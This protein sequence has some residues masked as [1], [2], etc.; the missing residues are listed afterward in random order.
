MGQTKHPPRRKP[1]SLFHGNLAWAFRTAIAAALGFL[2][3]PSPQHI[4]VLPFFCAVIS[5]AC[6]QKTVGQ[7]LIQCFDTLVGA[8]TGGAI[9]S[10]GAWI[11]LQ[12]SNLTYQ[13]ALPIII[14][15]IIIILSHPLVP[16]KP[17]AFTVVFLG[18]GVP[19]SA[20]VWYF[21]FALTATTCVGLAA[22]IVAN[23]LPLLHPRAGCRQTKALLYK[24]EKLT[25]KLILEMVHVLKTNDTHETVVLVRGYRH[26]NA[27]VQ[28]LDSLREPTR[29]E[30]RLI[31]FLTCCH[32][33]RT[34][35]KSS[36]GDSCGWGYERRVRLLLCQ[37]VWLDGMRQSVEQ[38][39]GEPIFPDQRRFIERCIPSYIDLVTVI[40]DTMVENGYKKHKTKTS[41]PSTF[42][43]AA[44]TAVSNDIANK[45]HN[46]T[47]PTIKNA[48]FNKTT[49]MTPNP[50]ATTFLRPY[51]TADD[52]AKHILLL[53]EKALEAFLQAR[54]EVFYNPMFE[55][56]KP[57]LPVLIH[58]LRRSAFVFHMSRLAEEVSKP[59]IFLKVPKTKFK[60]AFDYK[61]PIKMALALLIGS[62]WF[63]VPGLQGVSLGRGI[64][65]GVT[66]CFLSSADI[67]SSVTKSLDRLQGSLLACAF[68][69]ITIRIVGRNMVAAAVMMCAW[70]FVTAF[71]RGGK[72]HGYAALVAAFSSP[73]LLFGGV[74]F[75]GSAA[76]DTF[77][78][79]RVEMTAIGVAVYLAIQAFIWPVDPVHELEAESAKWFQLAANFA[80]T[81]I[82][83]TDPSNV[84]DT[85]IRSS[86][87]NVLETQALKPKP[88]NGADA[89]KARVQ[90]AAS[91]F[92]AKSTVYAAASSPM[93]HRRPFAHV[94]YLNLLGKQERCVVH[95]A[96]I[97][98]ALKHL[99]S[100]G[101][102]EDQKVLQVLHEC[103]GLIATQLS[104]AAALV[105][106]IKHSSGWDSNMHTSGHDDVVKAAVAL[107]QFSLLQARV[108]HLWGEFLHDAFL[109]RNPTLQH[110]SGQLAPLGPDPFQDGSRIQ[111][112]EVRVV[113]LTEK[114]EISAA[115][116]EDEKADSPSSNS[117]KEAN[118]VDCGKFFTSDSSFRSRSLESRLRSQQRMVASSA[119]I[120]GMSELC[121]TLAKAGVDIETIYF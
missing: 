62:L 47:T 110:H 77:I 29:L 99:G 51:E 79:A 46:T 102:M 18:L 30:M 13:I 31:C 119:I 34:S 14:F 78:L 22:A 37:V 121:A 24:A 67:G 120:S 93:P 116:T 101:G 81:V 48:S 115:V 92:K 21:G 23:L 75:I 2:L 117:I 11:L 57:I 71:F 88:S 56:G 42:S 86:K 58:S 109:R 7:T 35:N 107:R 113:D 100:G 89:D 32:C 96:Q 25:Q 10:L 40:G 59:P 49:S 98:E 103:A 64:W 91:L 76:I 70:V 33:C 54:I 1:E 19:L 28:E 106:A 60:L 61:H 74:Q 15:F 8:S 20:R 53:L 26:L 83:L 94:A 90:C 43:T 45:D 4:F 41:K 85:E 108:V 69:I 87:A 44:A 68:S 66:I 63:V 50:T 114:A 55:E 73:V 27:L 65:I 80:A 52:N 5:I 16:A 84:N 104:S 3:V 118:P 95:M 72:E 97:A 111:I 112:V 38:R 39:Q 82:P 17:F 12:Q 105:D 9:S 36:S 6:C